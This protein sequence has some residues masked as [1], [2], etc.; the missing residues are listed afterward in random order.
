MINCP[1]LQKKADRYSSIIVEEHRKPKSE[2][3]H[4]LL[5]IVNRNKRI[6]RWI[7]ELQT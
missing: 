6:M 1:G 3:R 2:R 5:S 4:D 7:K